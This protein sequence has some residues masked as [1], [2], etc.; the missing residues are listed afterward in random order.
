MPSA[1]PKKTHTSVKD[2]RDMVG[3]GTKT[4]SA[5]VQLPRT[6]VYGAVESVVVDVGVDVLVAV[7]EVVL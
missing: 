5:P 6:I 4:T 7:D 1:L 2:E 3:S